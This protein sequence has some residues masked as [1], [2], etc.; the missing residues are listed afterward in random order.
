ME[1][2]IN[3]LYARINWYNNIELNLKSIK[4]P[5]TNN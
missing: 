1:H 3:L 5:Y 4:N 2:T